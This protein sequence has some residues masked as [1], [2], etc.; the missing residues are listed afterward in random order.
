[1]PVSRRLRF[2]ILRRDGHVC[3]YCGAQAPDVALTVDHVMPTALGGSDDPDNLVTACR[4]CNAGKSSSSPDARIVE[5]VSDDALRWAK[6]M[7]HAA[8][9]QAM[10][11]QAA[12]V[13]IQR[14][15]EFWCTWT[16]PGGENGAPIPVDRPAD[17]KQT[18]EH[19]CEL[20]L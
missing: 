1:M 8:G 6:A 20:G 13:Y 11:S 5:N 4:D 2:E 10:K 14:F 19:W 9:I 16:Y 17:W 18:L 3:R 15:D 7:E 12:H